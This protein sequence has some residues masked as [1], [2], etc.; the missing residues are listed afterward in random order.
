MLSL[1]HL[2]C[3]AV[4]LDSGDLPKALDSMEEALKLSQASGERYI[5]GRALAWLGRA[6]AKQTFR[7]PQQQKSASCR[8]SGSW[9]S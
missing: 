2:L 1:A 6:W 8:G 5:E 7:K 9:R 4:R 3:G